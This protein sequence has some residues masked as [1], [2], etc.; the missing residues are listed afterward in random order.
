MASPKSGTWIVELREAIRQR[1]AVGQTFTASDIY[2]LEADFSQRHSRNHHV[3]AKL[4]QTL[5]Y[6]RDE[7]FIKFVD[8]RGLYCRK[9]F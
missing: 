2:R 7:G 4:Q 8:N 9:G 5:Q 3:I 6:L 1:W